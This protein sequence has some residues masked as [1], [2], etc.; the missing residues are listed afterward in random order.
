MVKVVVHKV[1]VCILGHYD[2]D[3]M[4]WCWCVGWDREGDENNQSEV[5]TLNVGVRVD[6]HTSLYGGVDGVGNLSTKGISPIWSPN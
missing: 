2:V 5:A 6:R 1:T 3:G 4:L